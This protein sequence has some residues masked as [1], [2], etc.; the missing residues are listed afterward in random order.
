MHETIPVVM[1]V[2]LDVPVADWVAS[3]GC[4]PEEAPSDIRT[5]F[6]DSEVLANLRATNAFGP[7]AQPVEHEVTVL[8]VEHRT[9]H[10][11]G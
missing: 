10:P 3:Y 8:P 1:T 9:S 2:R 4:S 6:E 7:V 11:H 5:Y